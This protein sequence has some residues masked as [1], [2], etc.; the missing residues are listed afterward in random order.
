MHEDQ[1]EHT[2]DEPV[3]EPK[4]QDER[5]YA[6]LTPGEEQVS[7][8]IHKAVDHTMAEANAILE[9]RYKS[10]AITHLETALMFFNK[11]IAVDGIK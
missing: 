11:A 10:I 1:E 2:H 3:K 6:Q 9:G 8:S 7:L 4:Q 5:G